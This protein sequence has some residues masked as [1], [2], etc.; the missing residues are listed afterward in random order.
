M[1]TDWRIGCRRAVL[2]FLVVV[3]AGCAVFAQNQKPLKSINYILSMSNPKSHLF[4]VKIEATL[5][6]GSDSETIEF[7]MPKWS[8][9]RYSVFDFAK[10]VQ[11][12]SAASGVCPKGSICKLSAL[13]VDRVNDQTWRVGTRGLSA[14]TL[15]YN[16]F[17]D[18]LSGTFSQLNE[19]HANFNGGSIFMYVVDHKPDPVGLTINPPQSW[20]ITNGRTDR[21]DQREWQF[22]N[23]D[24]IIDTPTEIAPDF[25]VDTFS[26]DGKQYRVVVHSLG[27]EGGKRPELVRGIEKIVRAETAMWGPPE[28]QSYTFLIHFA[29]DDHS[30]DG[31][32]HLT[33]TQIIEPGA[34]ADS[35]MLEDALDTASHEFFH[36]WNVKRL[37][38]VGLGPW[39]FTKDARTRGLWVAEGFT[40]Y[41]GH[42]MQRRAGIWTNQQ[43]LDTLGTIISRV[44]NNPGT[45][46]MS[47]VES[48]LSAPFIDGSE[49]TQKTNLSNTSVSYYFKGEVIALVLDSLIRKQ[50]NGRASLDDVMRQMYDEFYVKS[51]N[52]S[53]YLRG[54]G[55][56]V[57]DVERSASRVAGTDL[58][59]FFVRYVWGVE[60]LPYEEALAGIGVA[61]NREQPKHPSLGVY[62]E[63]G[64]VRTVVSGSP[65]AEA[66]ISQGDELLEIGGAKLGGQE[67]SSVI[68]K[69][70]AGDSIP[71]TLKRDRQTIKTTVKLFASNNGNYKLEPAKDS[72]GVAGLRNGWLA[73]TR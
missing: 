35:G 39:D 49:S 52:D 53:Y 24:I 8:P 17:G 28:F 2:V 5:A 67:I 50:T 18:D 72:S 69:Y 31:M 71:V 73:G 40:N 30:G 65:A 66:G 15:T 41:Y 6:T 48:S 37:R 10:N 62:S 9:G 38:P 22:S 3:L 29:A 25:S 68:A 34:L 13:P 33:S 14:V 21:D 1:N 56:E 19:K 4:E 36:V 11:E 64:K 26:V 44:E 58:H 70:K 27:N 16:V 12:V 45:R 47:A 20:R 51:P 59:D 46:L 32:E 54:K 60:R 23:Y 57:E 7:Q 43:L 42:V 55:Y 61:V 63:S